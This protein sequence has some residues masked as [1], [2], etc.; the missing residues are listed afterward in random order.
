MI[1]VWYGVPGPRTCFEAYFAVVI[2]I[3]SF[4]YVN[5][6]WWKLL[7]Y[8]V[9]MISDPSLMVFYVRCFLFCFCPNIYF[10]IHIIC[11]ITK[12]G[13]CDVLMW[14]WPLTQPKHYW[15]LDSYRFQKCDLYHFHSVDIVFVQSHGRRQN[16]GRE[17]C[18]CRNA[19]HIR[20]TSNSR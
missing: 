7:W 3:P 1:G 18:L 2:I 9:M 16:T 6:F 13:E 5:C 17:L 11:R 12:R 19:S 8:S 15:E 20:S 10:Q 14:T 4:D